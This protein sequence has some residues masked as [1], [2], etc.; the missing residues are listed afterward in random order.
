MPTRNPEAGPVTYLL[1]GEEGESED[2]SRPGKVGFVLPC[3]APPF[4]SER[5]YARSVM[6]AGTYVPDQDVLA[7]AR[8]F[9]EGGLS[10][11]PG[12]SKTATTSRRTCS[13]RE[14]LV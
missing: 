5:V 11:S 4:G 10:T 13:H 6:L 3:V 12:S 8:V 7:L 2:A 1:L 14:G 9:R